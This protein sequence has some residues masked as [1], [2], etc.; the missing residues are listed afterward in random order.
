MAHGADGGAPPCGCWNACEGRVDGSLA[1]RCAALTTGQ[2]GPRCTTAHYR[3]DDR[4]PGRS[5]AQ[6][7]VGP[8]RRPPVRATVRE[9]PA[10]SVARSADAGRRGRHVA[11][12]PTHYER[13]QW[14]TAS[15]GCCEM[16]LATA[17]LA[18]A[19]RG[20]IVAC[21]DRMGTRQYQLGKCLQGDQQAMPELS[22]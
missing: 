7:S 17:P 8:R 16:P 1:Y 12:T 10:A 3:R 20:R 14:S 18:L 15:N 19:R 13:V 9:R 6:T 5:Q 4:G 11:V 21:G 2:A 22:L